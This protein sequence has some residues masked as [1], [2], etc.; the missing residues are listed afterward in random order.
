MSVSSEGK[1]ILVYDV[2]SPWPIHGESIY[3][4]ALVL[5]GGGAKGR[6]QIGVEAALYQAGIGNYIEQV[7]GTSVGAL[8]GL[9]TGLFC[10]DF[11]K[12]VS[13]WESIISNKQIFK[14]DLNARNIFEIIG[15]AIRV[16]NQ[17]SL[18]DPKPL[19]D[20]L[21]N[22]FMN[23]TLQDIKI[24]NNIDIAIT[25]ADLNRQRAEVYASYDNTKMLKAADVGRRSS[26]IPILF[27]PVPGKDYRDNDPFLHYHVDGGI[28]INN[29]YELAVHYFENIRGLK[30]G[31]Y[32][33][34]VIKCNKTEEQK[35]DKAYTKI[36]D[37]AQRTLDTILKIQEQLV[38]EEIDPANTWVFEPEEGVDT[39]DI[40]NFAGNLSMLQYGYD[41]AFKQIEQVRHFLKK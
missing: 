14:G 10:Q 9:L 6:F 1:T 28:G 4:T 33:V 11:C 35:T 22:V 39:G 12:A 20:L 30:R 25:S 27:P 15:M 19:D 34:I 17:S 24:M 5:M 31:E 13:F 37:I 8:N 36:L 29:P 21:N 23:L 2:P 40:M 41:L 38:D 16:L 26:R 32:K 18:L 3:P 7:S